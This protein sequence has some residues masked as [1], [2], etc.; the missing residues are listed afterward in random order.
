MG[1]HPSIF[2][3][4][5]DSRII[6][7]SPS[8]IHRHPICSQ[9]VGAHPPTCRCRSD[10]APAYTDRCVAVL[11]FDM[12]RGALL[13]AHSLGHVY[14]TRVGLELTTVQAQRLHVGLQRHA[15]SRRTRARAW[16]WPPRRQMPV[17]IVA[18]ARDQSRRPN[19]VVRN[20]RGRQEV[21]HDPYPRLLACAML[22][23]I[24]GKRTGS[25][26]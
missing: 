3:L 25:E 21:Q 14:P 19:R 6:R 1:P 5:S 17:V 8:S 18:L 4:T 26:R 22:I 7:P 12:L 11:R 10:P 20:R 16:V 9:P 24:S 13:H 2:I 23:E 15:V